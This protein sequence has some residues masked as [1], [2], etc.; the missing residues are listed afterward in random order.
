VRGEEPV[1][2]EA[3][4]VRALPEGGCDH[5]LE[6]LRLYRDAVQM[7]VDS[8]WGL[9]AKLSKKRL[10]RLFYNDLVSLG[11]RAHHAKEVYLYAKSLVDSA[12]GSG[13]RKP[14]LRRLSARIDRYDY[15]LDLGN[16]TLTLK[17]HSGYE[18]KLRL[19][20]SRGRVE[21]FRGWSNYELVVK[22][23][24]GGFWV[25]VY[26]KR[27]V[28]TVEP[29]TVMSI[30]L[31]FDNVTLAVLTLDG[32]LIRLKRFKTPHRRIL[33][34]R[35]WIERIQGR[36]P[37][38]WRFTKGIR[39]A[40]ERHGERIRSTS[41]DYAH[42]LGD[43]IAE[44][45][46]RFRSVVV[47]E[48]LEKLRENGKKNR[49]FNKRLGLWFYRRVRF[50]VEYEAR[51]RGLE[52]VKVDPRGTSSKCPRC[53]GKL[54]ENGYRVLRCR[55]C[56]F[57]GD[58]DVTATIN[59]YKKYVSRYSR[60]GVPGVALN[61]PKPDEAPSGMRGNRDEAMKNISSCMNSYES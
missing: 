32:K 26:F 3:F 54:V 41:R 48:D 29:R 38:S 5:L 22:Y 15:R 25:S 11:L 42:K 20:T 33:T 36:Y 30:D 19:V 23:D 27:S 2:V 40:I 46:L 34:H 17:L 58:R 60:C 21:R 45:A 10:H 53:G 51:E 44:L 6:F 24:K 55:K 43:L 28:R 18:V 39:E 13:G 16:T 56:S 12:R 49:R 14:V 31:N 52:I 57:I 35:I 50:C 8:V 7:V 59:L 47:L 4:R 1:V 9:K 37:R 61:A